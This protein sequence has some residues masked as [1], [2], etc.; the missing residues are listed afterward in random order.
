[1]ERR[2]SCDIYGYSR[3]SLG[4]D[5]V[6]ECRLFYS[7]YISTCIY[8]F[9]FRIQAVFTVSFF[10]FFCNTSYGTVIMFFMNYVV[11]HVSGR[12]ICAV[13]SIF[14]YIWS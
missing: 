11:S 5:H 1:M 9:F 10:L 12:L 3:E 14:I 7:G 13:F 4:S 6:K 8:Q 2:F